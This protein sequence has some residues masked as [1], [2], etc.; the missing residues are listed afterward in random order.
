M[1]KK[2]NRVVEEGNTC[3]LMKRG[4]GRWRRQADDERG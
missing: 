4:S 2:D 3:S 1:I